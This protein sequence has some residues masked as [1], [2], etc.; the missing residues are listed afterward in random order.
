MSSTAADMMICW[1]APP[2]EGHGLQ[3]EKSD[4]DFLPL[5]PTGSLQL[6]SKGNLTSV[7]SIDLVFSGIC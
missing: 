6:L 5:E 4:H 1:C 2:G 3:I 7:A